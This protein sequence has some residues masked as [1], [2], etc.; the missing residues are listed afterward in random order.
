MRHL[1]CVK[2]APINHN[3]MNATSAQKLTFFLIENYAQSEKTV[4][5][6]TMLRNRFLQ[7]FLVGLFPGE[8]NGFLM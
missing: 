1:L 8:R 7:H 3:D 4:N 2:D 6:S 5:I